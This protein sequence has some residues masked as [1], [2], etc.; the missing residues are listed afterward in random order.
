LSG[1][2]TKRYG[3]EYDMDVGLEVLGLL[4]EDASLEPPGNGDEGRVIGEEAERCAD[5]VNECSSAA[6]A[7]RDSSS[8]PLWDSLSSW[9]PTVHPERY[10]GSEYAIAAV[11]LVVVVRKDKDTGGHAVCDRSEYRSCGASKVDELSAP[12]CNAYRDNR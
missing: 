4:A 1:C 9:T 10:V 11:I 2:A 7:S 3:W 12:L 8:S 5:S 6:V